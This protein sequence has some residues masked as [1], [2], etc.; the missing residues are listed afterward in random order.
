MSAPACRP[1]ALTL[2]AALVAD[3]LERVHVALAGDA[4]SLLLAWRD[5]VGVGP[6]ALHDGGIA[7]QTGVARGVVA[8]AAEALGGRRHAL[9]EV[10]SLRRARQ[11]GV[12]RGAHSA[13][14]LVQLP[15]AARRAAHLGA[16]RH[17]LKVR[18]ALGVGG[19]T[20]AAVLAFVAHGVGIFVLAVAVHLALHAHVHVWILEVEVAVDGRTRRAGAHGRRQN[21][22]TLLL[23]AGSARIG[24]LGEVRPLRQLTVHVH[25]R[26]GRCHR[27]RRA[28]AVVERVHG[29]ATGAGAVGAA[30]GGTGAL[31]GAHLGCRRRRRSKRARGAEREILRREGVANVRDKMRRERESFAV[32]VFRTALQIPQRRQS[33]GYVP[34]VRVG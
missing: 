24:A 27:W 20:Q 33:V 11:P 32:F 10:R 18:V 30:S 26:H 15:V 1:V 8:R 16:G 5:S 23:L 7:H 22:A 19:A 34:N 4:R 21:V 12:A 3:A 31:A 25:G 14:R 9:V 17:A 2:G 6:N 13:A 29:V 28:H